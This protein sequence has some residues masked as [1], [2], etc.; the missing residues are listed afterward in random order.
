MNMRMPQILSKRLSLQDFRRIQPADGRAGP[1]ENVHT[2]GQKPTVESCEQ[3]PLH[4]GC[5]FSTLA[6]AL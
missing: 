5:R 6:I 2:S 4:T 1:D 3:P